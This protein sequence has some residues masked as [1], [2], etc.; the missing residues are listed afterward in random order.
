[1]EADRPATLRAAALLDRTAHPRRDHPWTRWSSTGPG[2][3]RPGRYGRR[4]LDPGCVDTCG[5]GGDGAGYLQHLHGLWLRSWPPAPV[6]AVAKHGNRAASSQNRQLRTCWRRWGSTVDLPVEASAAEVRGRRS[7]SASSSPAAPIRRCASP[8]ADSRQELGFR[9][10][11]NCGGAPVFNPV[12]NASPASRRVYGSLA[13]WP[14]LGQRP[15][16]SWVHRASAWSCMAATDLDEI[17]TTGPTTAMCPLETGPRSR[18]A[19]RSTPPTLGIQ[20]LRRRRT[21]PGATLPEN[22]ELARAECLS[23]ES[24]ARPERSSWLECRAQRSGWADA[25]IGLARGGAS[26]KPASQPG[27]RRGG[28]PS[29]T[30]WSQPAKVPPTRF[31]VSDDPRRDPRSTS[32]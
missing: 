5:T 4:F 10:I 9:T 21:S 24:R 22:A 8:G 7:A 19:G 23:R 17:T 15:G 3:A 28:K 14:L 13:W 20:K 1:M 2:P 27:Y 11:V 6:S 18:A 30:P 29:S 12:G 25:G 26:S 16:S 31:D 32:V